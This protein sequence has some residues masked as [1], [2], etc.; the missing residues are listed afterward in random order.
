MKKLLYLFILF[1]ITCS[2]YAQR[3]TRIGIQT[4]T[5]INIA[6]VSLSS[7]NNTNAFAFFAP[8]LVSSIHI[9]KVISINPGLNYNPIG[10]KRTVIVDSLLTLLTNNKVNN[11]NVPLNLSLNL[12]AGKGKLFFNLGPSFA[13]SLDGTSIVDSVRGGLSYKTSIPFIFGASN[14]ELKRFNLGSNFGLGYWWP[15]GFELKSNYGF[16]NDITKTN[17]YQLDNTIVHLSASFYF[18]GNRKFWNKKKDS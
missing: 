4:G 9:N 7:L 17:L 5:S 11:I 8:G 15:S 3:V 10:F 16:L 2:A 14:S 12:K 13:L 6:K 1:N 18:L